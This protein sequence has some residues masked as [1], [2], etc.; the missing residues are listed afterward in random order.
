MTKKLALLLMIACAACSRAPEPEGRSYEVSIRTAPAV[1]YT[2][3]E[4]RYRNADERD[5]GAYADTEN[6]TWLF[7]VVF[8]SKE[9]GPLRVESA[10]A[11]FRKGGK[12]LW[13][14]A[15]TRSYL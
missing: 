11:S 1:I 2:A 5:A 13:K 10:E 14:E 8:E 15:Y 12:E 6:V 9:S 4:G 7:H 3:H